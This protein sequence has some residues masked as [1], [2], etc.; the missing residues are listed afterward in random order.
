MLD[1]QTTHTETVLDAQKKLKMAQDQL[2]ICAAFPG[3]VVEAEGC[4]RDALHSAGV[5]LGP[6]HGLPIVVKD[7]IDVAGLPT[8][9]GSATRPDQPDA[10]SD[11]TVVSKLRAAG[12]VTVG[13]THT[14]EFAFGGW[15][16]NASQ[17]TPRNPWKPD[18]PHTPGGSSNGTGVAVGGRFVPAGLGTDT[19]G[20]VRIPAAFCGCVGLKTSIGLVSRAG[21]V[22]LSDTFD[23]VG[24]LTDTVTRAAQ[25][26]TVMQGEDRADPTTL[27]IT[28]LD[29][30]AGL[31]R[32]ISGLRLGRLSADALE[33][34]SPEVMAAFD[35]AVG[36]LEDAG[37]T[38]EVF[39]F[40]KSFAEYQ[41]SATAIISSDAYAFHALLADSNEAPLNDTTRM[42]I[43]MGRDLGA[44]ER[45]QAQRT[46]Q[47][48]IAAF[49]E[50]MDRLDAIVLPTAPTTAIP[51]S[52]V[53]ENNYEMSLYT[54]V[55][56]YLELSALSVPIGLTPAG[57][58]TSLQ[59]VVR[60]FQDPLALRIGQAFE[61][62]R[63]AMQV[64]PSLS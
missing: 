13:K 14:V 54:R 49:L 20:S 52:E 61:K 36:L 51:L 64:P 57:L 7:I 44:K 29:P 46:R 30:L 47:A 56:N 5:D 43:L 38:I 16:T 18:E 24:P 17:G 6:L 23:T 62:V 2:H 31:D 55:S 8:R 35:T 59:I 10:T 32:G 41:A 40:P 11:A 27:G 22:P 9:A 42:R 53:D 45:V 21:V 19:G 28:R 33:D 39:D 15:G 60:R 50:K 58:P 37:A 26:L 3:D 12:A 25:M 34:S 48:D 63:G 4:H 1:R